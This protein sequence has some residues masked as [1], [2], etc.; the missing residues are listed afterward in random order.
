MTTLPPN[1][2]FPSRDSRNSSATGEDTLRLL[3]GLPAPAGLDERL[4]A[5]LRQS[6]QTGRILIWRGPLRPVGGWMHASAFRGA[7]AAAIVCAVAGGGWQMYSHL[8]MPP[9]AKGI[10]APS[11]GSGF[12]TAGGLRRPETLEGP[13]LKHAPD[14]TSDSNVVEKLPGPGKAVPA[15]KTSKPHHSSIK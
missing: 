13:V 15:V 11:A 2:H 1:G 8:Q 4:K 10:A 6:P 5:G 9:T 14:P 12:S 3:A 7:A